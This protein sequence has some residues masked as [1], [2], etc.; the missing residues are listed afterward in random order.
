MKEKSFRLPPQAAKRI[1]RSVRRKARIYNPEDVR[2]NLESMMSDSRYNGDIRRVWAAFRHKH[3]S[4]EYILDST[5][6]DD[7]KE[8]NYMV[9]RAGNMIMELTIKALIDQR[10]PS[11]TWKFQFLGF[12]VE[13]R[14]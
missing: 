2:Y 13:I 14:R 3:T 4:Y 7:E 5:R 9:R 6:T 12:K 10:E 8:K 11:K 1:G